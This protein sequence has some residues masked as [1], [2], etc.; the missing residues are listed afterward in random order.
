MNLKEKI[1]ARLLIVAVS[2]VVLVVIAVSLQSVML[3]KNPDPGTG[4][5]YTYYNNFLIFRGSFYHLLENQNLYQAYPQEHYD[6]FKYSPTFALLLAPLALLP[7]KA[8]LFFWN[9]LNALVLF[10]AIYTLPSLSDKKKIL[11]LG[12][13][14]IELVTSLQ[15]S[16]SNALM[17]GLVILSFIYLEKEKTWGASLLIVLSIFIKIYSIVALVLFIFYPKKIQSALGIFAWFILFGLLP[18]LLVSPPELL[19]HYENWLELLQ[20]DH[21][22]FGGLSVMSWL[23]SWFGLEIN[24]NLVALIGALLLVAPL[25][26]LKAYASLYFRLNFLA[27]ALIWMVIFN[28]MAESPTFVIA[29]SGVAIWFFL[30]EKIRVED[31][32]LVALVLVFTVLSPTDLFPD[33]LR[34]SLVVPYVLKATTCIFVW[35]KIQVEL[36]TRKF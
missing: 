25:A 7:A 2:V 33:S 28:H 9:L 17:A 23:R 29:V 19:Q 27:S 20:G 8:G 3:K 15:N 35:M 26:R 12:L 36:I 31:V 21:A 14:L 4:V 22:A 5:A 11:A 32:V 18:L 13:V 24:K 6:L 30:K 16:Q 1:R 34:K 10:F